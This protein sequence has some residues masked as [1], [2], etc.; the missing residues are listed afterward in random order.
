VAHLV[1]K[2]KQAAEEKVAVTR[3]KFIC[4][5]KPIPLTYTDKLTAGAGD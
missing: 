3:G 2:K 1:V 4:A 5:G